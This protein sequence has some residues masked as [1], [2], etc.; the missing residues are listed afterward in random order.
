MNGTVSIQWQRSSCA[1]ATPTRPGS[2]PMERPPTI[3]HRGRTTIIGWR[4]PIDHHAAT[5]STPS[6][7]TAIHGRTTTVETRTHPASSLTYRMCCMI[8]QRPRVVQH[9]TTTIVARAATTYPGAT[10]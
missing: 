9:G 1:H 5:S 7:T 4:S 6:S 3:H 2:C 10:V 8:E